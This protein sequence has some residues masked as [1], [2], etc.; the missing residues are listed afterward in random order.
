MGKYN[1]D[2][3]IE[4]RGTGALKTDALA[5]RFGRDDLLSAWVADMD[6]AT[7]DFIR[8]ALIERISGNPILGY[9]IEPA[10]Y[11]PSIIDWERNLHNWELKPEW[12][13]YIPGIVKGIGMVINVFT[14]PGDDV[15]IMPPVYHPFRITAEEN[16]RNVVNIPLIEDSRKRYFINFDA[17]EN[18]QTLGGVLLLS[19]PHNPGGRMWTEDELKRLADICKKKGLLVVSD[20]IHADMALWG[21]THVPF[22]TVSEEA[23]SNSITFCAPS[24]TFNI[25]GIVSSFSVV[26]DEEIRSQF[27]GWLAANEFGDAPL[28]SHI[29][30]ISAYRKGEEW[31]KEM[32]SYVES[33]IR[34]VEDFCRENIPGVS[35]LRP[36]ASFLVW[37][38]CRELGLSHDEL[39]DL[40]VNKACVALNDGEMF[41]KEGA[42]MM[43]L[44]VAAPRATLEKVM[45]RIKNAVA[46]LRKEE[47]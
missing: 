20:E 35:A 13:S 17:L 7:P 34:Y 47:Q 22:A 4:R 23:A 9:T 1:F 40:F 16:G 30:T 42:G 41:G 33:N 11:K 10:D 38:D 43:R 26:P 24:K 21:K 19:N 46:E 3:V 15:V 25:P 2:E 29:A 36:D 28:L 12:L 39:I 32:I 18:L 5:E 45:N 44:N 8:E 14:K 6:F 31:R 27:Y 37:L